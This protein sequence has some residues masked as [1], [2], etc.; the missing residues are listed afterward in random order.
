MQTILDNFDSGD[1][2]FD[3]NYFRQITEEAL[4]RIEF[5]V[6]RIDINPFIQQISSQ[7]SG[8]VRSSGDR[9][10]IQNLLSETMDNLYNVVS[11][12]FTDSVSS[13]RKSLDNMQEEFSSRLLNQIQEEFDTLCRQVKDKEHSI[14]NYN[15]LISLLGSSVIV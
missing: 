6:I 3:I 5:P 11:E 15:K 14:E 7:F 8:E 9:A 10:R 12:Q 2:N 13:F 4:N 1:E